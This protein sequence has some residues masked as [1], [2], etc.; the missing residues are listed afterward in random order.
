MD[1][2]PTNFDEAYKELQQ[3]AEELE[4]QSIPVEK[5]SQKMDRAAT[6]TAFCKSRLRKIEEDLEGLQGQ[7]N[8]AD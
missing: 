2:T 1:K 4:D 7:S 8:E 5:L 3:I 6:L